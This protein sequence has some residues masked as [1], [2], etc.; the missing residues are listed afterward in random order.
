M[1]FRLAPEAEAE[2]DNIWL[3]LARGADGMRAKAF[4]HKAHDEG[5]AESGSIEVANSAIGA[6]TE[7][8][9]LLAQHPQG[10]RPSSACKT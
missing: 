10:E 6:I 2:L 5:G 8:F 3:H 7:L 9:F 1:G 4:G